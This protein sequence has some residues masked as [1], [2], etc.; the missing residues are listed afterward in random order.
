MRSTRRI[1]SRVALRIMHTPLTKL[2]QW[3]EWVGQLRV[4]QRTL[5]DRAP[6]AGRLTLLINTQHRVNDITRKRQRKSRNLIGAARLRDLLTETNRSRE[7][8]SKLK[9]RLDTLFRF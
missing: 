2:A 9:N 7:R 1:S 5:A 3:E 6:A 8:V 4:M